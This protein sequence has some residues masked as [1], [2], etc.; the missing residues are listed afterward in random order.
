MIGPVA[1]HLFLQGHWRKKKLQLLLL[2]P[3]AWLLRKGA[4]WARKDRG[5]WCEVTLPDVCY[6]TWSS[7]LPSLSCAP[8][9]FKINRTSRAWWEHSQY[10]IPVFLKIKNAGAKAI[11]DDAREEGRLPC[12][13]SHFLYISSCFPSSGQQWQWYLPKFWGEWNLQAVWHLGLG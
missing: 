9:L 8:I 10:A 7:G 11:D 6:L 2:S 4:K 3:P 13:V 1:D 12:C 5:H